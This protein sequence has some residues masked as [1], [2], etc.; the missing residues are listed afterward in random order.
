MRF[1]DRALQVTVEIGGL[2]AALLVHIFEGADILLADPRL[3]HTNEILRPIRAIFPETRKSE[4]DERAVCRCV[5][6]HFLVLPLRCLHGSD[7]HFRT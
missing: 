7:L 6:G 2:G 4:K 5:N 1:K 3:H